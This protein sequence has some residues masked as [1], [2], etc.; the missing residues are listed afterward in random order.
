[1]QQKVYIHQRQTYIRKLLKRAFLIT[2]ASRESVVIQL[3]AQ[4]LPIVNLDQE[5]HWKWVIQFLAWQLPGVNLVTR[6]SGNLKLQS[7]HSSDQELSE[8]LV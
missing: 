6:E 1:M 2:A 4:Q 8:V 3:L 5:N 7:T